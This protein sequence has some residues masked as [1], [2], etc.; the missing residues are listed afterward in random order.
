[1]VGAGAEYDIASYIVSRYFG[2]THYMKIF[3]TMMGVITV[4]LCV[5]PVAFGCLLDSSGSYT[6][7]VM[8]AMGLLALGAVLFLFLGPYPD[9]ESRLQ[10]LG[11]MDRLDTPSR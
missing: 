8:I 11:V 6:P 2:L 1:G 3:G 10:P 5:T 4:C 9:N 7:I